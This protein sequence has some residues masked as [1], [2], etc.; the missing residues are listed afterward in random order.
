[1]SDRTQHTLLVERGR[2]IVQNSP[3]AMIDLDVEADGPAGFGSLLSIGAVSPWGDEFYRELKPTSDIWVQHNHDFCEDHGLERARLLTEG[4]EPTKAIVEL[5]A[6]TREIEKRYTKV[7]SVLCAFNTG[8]DFP[9]IDL[10]FQ[11][12]GIENPFGEAGFCIKSLAMALE[13][14]YDWQKTTRS[15]LPIYLLPKRDFTHHALEDARYQQQ[16]HFALAAALQGA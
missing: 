15:K 6:W 10:E 16:L 7:G 3:Q 8:F 9:W 12:A 2:E 11:K 13:P 5:D 4:M 14:E 1:M